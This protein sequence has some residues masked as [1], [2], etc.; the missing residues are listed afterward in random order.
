MSGYL[1]KYMKLKRKKIT[2]RDVIGL[3]FIIGG[4]V[5]AISFTSGF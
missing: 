5:L 3:A 4:L 2:W 1:I